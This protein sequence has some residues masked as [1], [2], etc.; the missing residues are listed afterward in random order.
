MIFLSLITS[1]LLRKPSNQYKTGALRLKWRQNKIVR[2]NLFE[3]VLASLRP[4]RPLLVGLDDSGHG[5]D[6]VEEVELAVEEGVGQPVEALDDGSSR[7]TTPRCM[8]NTVPTF[9]EPAHPERVAVH[10]LY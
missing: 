3:R 9:P 6:L 7:K 5:R 10:L 8:S 2:R 1:L 4:R